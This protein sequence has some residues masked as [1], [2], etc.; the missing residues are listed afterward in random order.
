MFSVMACREEEAEGDG[1]LV[2]TMPTRWFQLKMKR[3]SNKPAR[4]EDLSGLAL[5]RVTD[6]VQQVIYFLLGPNTQQNCELI[7][8]MQHIFESKL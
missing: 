8:V 6:S 5:L 3:N 7:A 2:L 4:S 1:G